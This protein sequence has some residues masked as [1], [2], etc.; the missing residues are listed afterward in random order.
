MILLKLVMKH[1][2]LDIDAINELVF[3]IRKQSNK[4]N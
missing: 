3:G 2:T 4:R 1:I